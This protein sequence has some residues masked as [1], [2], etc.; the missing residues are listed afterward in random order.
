MFAFLQ[1]NDRNFAIIADNDGQVALDDA[2]TLGKLFQLHDCLRSTC[3]LA[4]GVYVC[5]DY[6]TFYFAEISTR[7][8]PIDTGF[9]NIHGVAAP[10]VNANSRNII[11]HAAVPVAQLLDIGDGGWLYSLCIFYFHF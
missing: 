4:T 10:P 2:I 5:M 7:L 1:I 8:Q 6:E 3:A 9:S 11:G